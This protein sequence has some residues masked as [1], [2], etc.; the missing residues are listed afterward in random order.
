MTELYINNSDLHLYR[1]GTFPNV[2]KVTWFANK[3]D[4]DIL[5]RFTNLR[6][7]DCSGMGLTSLSAIKDL[8]Q[9][10]ILDCSSNR[11]TS[12]TEISG[13][14]LRTLYCHG[15]YIKAFDGLQNSTDLVELNCGVNNLISLK[16]LKACSKLRDLDLRNN[17]IRSVQVIEYLPN[18]VRI[19]CSYNKLRSIAVPKASQTITEL[20]CN[21]CGL[22]TLDGLSAYTGLHILKCRSNELTSLAGIESCA[23]LQELN[24]S[25]NRLVS[26]SELSSLRQLIDLKCTH[27]RIQSLEGIQACTLLERLCCSDNCLVTIDPVITLASLLIMNC[28][29]N[30]IVSLDPIIYLRLSTLVYV[31]NPLEIQ[32]MRCQR[33]LAQFQGWFY[34]PNRGRNQRTVYSDGQNVHDVHIQRSVCKSLSCLLTDPN[35]GCEGEL[36]AEIE[37]ADLT[38]HVKQLL[39]RYCAD[40]SIHSVH[41]ISYKELLGYVWARIIQSEHSTELIKILSQQV[42]DSEGMCFTG[43]FNRT[44]SVLVGYYDD[45]V[46]EI[47]DSSRISAIIITIQARINPYDPVTHAETATRELQEAGYSLDE[48]KPWIDAIMDTVSDLP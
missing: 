38:D 32:S 24:C 48:I 16:E 14:N 41:M 43:R 28:A 9:L 31:N 1:H 11:L 30:Q 34:S 20:R 6:E 37:K 2:S 25:G 35:P 10:K 29:H 44:L 39:S 18:L 40:Q 46:I 3:L 8:V 12:L 47:S 13:L 36:M 17:H 42:L 26:I 7:L 19:N 45:I 23:N 5:K 15:N 4:G 27:N 33:Y 22:N 21:N